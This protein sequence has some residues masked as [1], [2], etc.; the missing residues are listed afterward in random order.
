M[1]Q[2]HP[3]LR[4]E[5]ESVK[6]HSSALSQIKIF[7]LVVYQ[8]Q[9]IQTKILLNGMMLQLLEKEHRNYK[10]NLGQGNYVWVKKWKSLGISIVVN[11]L[12]EMVGLTCYPNWVQ[13]L[14]ELGG[15]LTHRLDVEDPRV[16]VGPDNSVGTHNCLLPISE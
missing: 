5:E 2:K 13:L 1:L 12:Q 10:S 3:G 8:L 16:D 14:G 6:K 9:N 15:E 7:L 4:Y 11:V